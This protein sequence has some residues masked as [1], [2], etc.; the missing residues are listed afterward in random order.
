M[1]FWNAVLHQTDSLIE[2]IQETD[3]TIEEWYKQREVQLNKNKVSDFELAFSSFFSIE[4][5]DQVLY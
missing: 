3:V 4:P 5:I 1:G 2:M